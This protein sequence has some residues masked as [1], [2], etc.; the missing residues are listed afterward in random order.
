MPVAIESVL[1]ALPEIFLGVQKIPLDRIR[2]NPDNPG[3]PIGESDIQD[4]VENLLAAGLKVPITLMPDPANPLAPGVTLHPDNPRLKADGTP[5]KV[6]DFNWI[7]LAGER[8]WRAFGRL[9]TQGWFWLGPPSPGHEPP[10]RLAQQGGQPM[11]AIPAYILN[12]SPGEAVEITHLDNDVRERGWWAHYQ[13]IENRIKADPDLTQAQVATRLKMNRNKVNRAISLL[14]LL[15]PEARA[16]ISTAS[17]N[18]NRNYL[19]DIQA[20]HNPSPLGGEGWVRGAFYP[21]NHPHPI[22]LPSREKGTATVK[23]SVFKLYVMCIVPI[24]IIEIRAF[25]SY[26]PPSWPILAPGPAS[27][28]GCGRK[29]RWRGKKPQSYG[30]TPLSQPKPRT[31][32]AEPWPWPLTGV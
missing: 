11:G 30:P 21:Q 28:R 14:P 16:L 5:W 32:F 10:Y 12:P 6:E 17:A 29:T 22:L 3:P 9:Q 23:H 4:M 1:A 8:R 7:I 27:S 26:P 18:S 25:L 31:W 15:N 24:Q 13:S 20:K 19:P 2:P